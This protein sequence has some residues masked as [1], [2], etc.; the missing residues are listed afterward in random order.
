MPTVLTNL[1]IKEV[2]SVDRGAGEGVRVV[3]MKRADE[4]ALIDAYMKR[5]FS[6]EQRQHATESGAAEPDGSYP[7]ENGGDLENAIRAVGRSK[8]PG[9]TRRHII[10]RARA[11][12]MSDKIPEEWKGGKGFLKRLFKA[13]GKPTPKDPDGDGD[14]DTTLDPEKNPDVLQDIEEGTL[15]LKKSVESIL[16]D[17]SLEPAQKQ[18]L[19]D[20]TFKQYGEH[21]SGVVPEAVAKAISAAGLI[22]KREESGTGKDGNMADGKDKKTPEQMQEDCEKLQKALAFERLPDAHKAF[23]KG[24]DEAAQAAWVAK[25]ADDREKAMEED[26]KKKE[27]D[28]K[29]NLSP[30][31]VAKLARMDG[32][33]A[34]LVALQK[35]EELTA[36]VAKAADIGLPGKGE[37]LQKAYGGDKAALDDLCSMLKAAVAQVQAAGLFREFGSSVGKSDENATAYDKIM[38]KAED[39]RKQ[40]PKLTVA[41]AFEK[42]YTDPANVELV[43]QHKEESTTKRVAA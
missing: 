35:K 40:D 7:I 33:E 6:D 9:K 5:E 14:D 23:A 3:L 20:E 26:K 37:V 22:V 8:N 11:L 34:Q 4:E 42:A 15:R 21:V 32:M 43:K 39:L 41:K 12:G 36:F 24:W 31:L 13:L 28:M 19:L 18:G 1:M 25:S 29:K 27:E 16:G 30:D 2:S 10:S 38:A 17:A